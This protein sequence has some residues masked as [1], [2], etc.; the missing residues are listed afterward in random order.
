M[1]T[2]FFHRSPAEWWDLIKQTFW[3]IFAPNAYANLYHH[4]QNLRNSVSEMEEEARCDLVDAENEIRQLQRQ[5]RE[6]QQ[7]IDE[8]TAQLRGSTQA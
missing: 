6:L 2:D 4:Y 3:R 7:R 5:N 8:L 1:N